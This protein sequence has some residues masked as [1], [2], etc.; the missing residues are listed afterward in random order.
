[1]DARDWDAKYAAAPDLL[2]SAGPNRFLAEE[3]ATLPPGRALDFA[4]GEGRNAIWLAEQGWRTTGVDFSAV[5][6]ERGRRIAAERGLA[7]GPVRAPGTGCVDVVVADIL[8]YEPEPRAFDLVAVF[9][10]Q[11]P[12]AERARALAAAARGVAPGG[13][14]LV[15]G[16][17]L[18]NLA[19]GVGGPKDPAVLFTPQDVVAEAC[20]EL[21]VER[22]TRVSRPVETE[23]GTRY[24]IDALVRARRPV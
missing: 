1:V 9:Y 10:L 6:V 14:L 18:L 7:A 21:E 3:A 22:A 8:A 24:A 15:V 12:A 5:A 20:G 11:L 16:H 19:K 23:Q 17:D 13:T 4:C 2:W